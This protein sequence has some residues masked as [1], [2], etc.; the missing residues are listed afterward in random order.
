MLN[1]EVKGV[2]DK[3]YRNW[4]QGVISEGRKMPQEEIFRLKGLK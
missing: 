2:Y 1:F 4:E 3:G